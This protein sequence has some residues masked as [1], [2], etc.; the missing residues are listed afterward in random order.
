M[1]SSEAIERGMTAIE[2]RGTIVIERA[3]A[4]PSG[5]NLALAT[6]D[7]EAWNVLRHLS[8]IL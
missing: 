3:K 1:N 2:E 7:A 6:A 8:R 4:K 5:K